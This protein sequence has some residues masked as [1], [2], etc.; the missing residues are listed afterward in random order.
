MDIAGLSTALSTAQVNN[1]VSVAVL[2]K[3][4]DTLDTTG[5]NMIKMMEASVYPNLGQNIDYSI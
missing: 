1:D 5:E 3:S 2:K 4:L